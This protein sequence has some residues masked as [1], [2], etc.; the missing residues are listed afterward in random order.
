M[1]SLILI[2]MS[3]RQTHL[4]VAADAVSTHRTPTGRECKPRLHLA[5]AGKDVPRTG[6]K[7]ANSRRMNPVRHF[8]LITMEVARAAGLVDR[9][10]DLVDHDLDRPAL[11]ALAFALIADKDGKEDA[12]QSGRAAALTAQHGHR[13]CIAAQTTHSY[14]SGLGDMTYLVEVADLVDDVALAA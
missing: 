9:R 5:H 11:E 4:T 3:P 10:G 7:T 6:G 13:H 12:V 8:A 2:H 14:G 1:G